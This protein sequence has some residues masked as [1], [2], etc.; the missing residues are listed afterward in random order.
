MKLGRGEHSTQRLAR[1]DRECLALVMSP[2]GGTVEPRKR[3][4]QAVE[5]GAKTTQAVSVT[6]TSSSLHETVAVGSV[7]NDESVVAGLVP[8]AP[9]LVSEGVAQDVLGD[10]DRHFGAMD[11]AE[12][13]LPLTTGFRA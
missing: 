7:R 6:W 9:T 8:R 10:H 3:L 5:L 11:K 13:L 2:P 4:G 1:P 12:S